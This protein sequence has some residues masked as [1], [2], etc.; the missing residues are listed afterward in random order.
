MWMQLAAVLMLVV[1]T[2]P[3]HADGEEAG[4]QIANA[5][6]FVP[7]MRLGRLDHA[8][9]DPRRPAIAPRALLPD[10]HAM[11][12][13]LAEQHNFT[14][15]L[16]YS[17]L[18]QG[19]SDTAVGSLA[20]T[21]ELRE[22]YDWLN[23]TDPAPPLQKKAAGGI[24]EF[25][26]KWTL[27]R[28]NTPNA[29][30]IGFGFEQRH[31]LGTVIN[32]QTLFLDNGSFW[33]T[34]SAFGEFD[35]G[36]LDLYYEQ[37]MLDGRLGFRVGKYLPFAVYDYF[38]LKNPKVAY[39]DFS[40]SLTPAVAWATWGMGITAYVKPTKQTYINFGIHDTNGGPQRGIETFFSE[41]EYFK[42]VDA[43]Y[44][45]R[46]D[47]GN[48]NIHAMFWDTDARTKAGRPSARGITVAGE[49][50]IGFLLPFARYSY[51]DGQAAAAEHFVAAGLGFKQVFG[52]AEDVIGI[53]FGWAKP[54]NKDLFLANQKS[55]EAFYRIQLTKELQ[56]TA[57]IT[58]IKDPPINLTE[59]DLTVFSIRGR[60]QL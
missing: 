29:G 47:F 11:K 18:Y 24:V 52:R 10:W 36:L 58:Y 33:P 59:D 37:S 32:P 17:A 23:L 40:F 26:G 5:D 16:A 48:G 6:A 7:E 54:A 12:K 56:V 1:A 9:L 4:F 20:G 42:V 49:Q 19:A 28:P 50:Q 39:N 44:N 22:I 57:G 55:I 25:S 21:R 43:G 3:A 15:T 45:T 27:I 35:P 53:G 46:F 30:F 13:R 34:G 2:L 60:F 51:Q 8:L 41:Q 38:S 31:R 14:F